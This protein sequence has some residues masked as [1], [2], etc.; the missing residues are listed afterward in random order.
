MIKVRVVRGVQASLPIATGLIAL[1][2]GLAACAAP[3][4]EADDLESS[5]SA[6]TVSNPGSGVFELGWAYGAPTGYSFTLTQSTTD[7]YVRARENM[8]FAIPAHFLW[9]HLHPNDPM[10]ADVA[11][12]KQLSAKVKAVYTKNGAA[13]SSSTVATTAWT[14]SET[15]NLSAT[16][17]SFT[18]NRRAQGVRFELTIKD[19]GDPAAT[20]TLGA[21]QFLE[22]PVI[23]GT[24]PNKTALFDN[25]G[26]TLRERILEGG[27]AVRGADLAVAY[28]DWRAATLID[29]SSVD[30][31]IGTQ[32]SFSRFG[33]IQVPIYGELE[34]EISYGVAIDG[35]W[36][37]ERAL[38]ANG[39]SRLMPPVGRVAY[40]GNVSIPKT[41]Q[42]LQ[43]YFHVKAFLKVDYARYSNITWKKYADGERLLVREKWDNENGAPGDNWDL[44]TEK[45]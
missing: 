16:T 35:V 5:D 28:T 11:R 24:L 33:A 12:L 15:W 2:S 9:S 44:E 8:S 18:V 37:D 3:D 32:T 14:G 10:P 41:A 7:E 17:P 6:Y 45:R 30:R 29:S 27:L 40:E 36:Q 31:Q 39:K 20:V 4:V 34:Y 26:P 43:F 1:S 23:G 21:D 19:A 38:T 42:G 25:Y 13:F 22:V